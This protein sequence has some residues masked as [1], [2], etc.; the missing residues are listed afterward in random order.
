MRCRGRPAVAPVTWS[1]GRSPRFEG[2]TIPSEVNYVGKAA[3]L[4]ELGYRE[5]GA[6]F[7]ITNYIST[8]W[9]WDRIRV[10]GGAYG[11]RI[12]FD[13]HSGGARYLSWRDPNLLAT[14]AVYD[15]TA[16]FLRAATLGEA[17]VTRNIIGTIGDIDQYRLPD[18]KGL[19]SLMRHLMGDT[20][21][22][23]QRLR[24]EVLSTSAADFRSFAEVLAEVAAHGQV[25]VLGSAAAM[26]AANASG[27]A[28][29]KYRSCCD[30][31]A[32]GDR[33][34]RVNGLVSAA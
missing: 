20:D 3:N 15:Q 19:A 27:P 25:T 9:L 17:E 26:A 31:G 28:F 16:D 4:Y 12:A 23:R 13:P 22:T 8:T 32:R 14:L 30:R 1:I 7:V 11:G 29:W 6:A 18:A 10:Q 33:R 21:E 34:D 2:L 5:N 24:E